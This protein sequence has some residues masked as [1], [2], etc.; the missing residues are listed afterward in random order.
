MPD[1][2]SI[3]AFSYKT[4]IVDDL[5]N[6]H[7]E[8]VGV[9]SEDNNLFRATSVMLM[10]SSRAICHSIQTAFTRWSESLIHIIISWSTA[11]EIQ[12][13]P[14]VFHSYKSAFMKECV[15]GDIPYQIRNLLVLHNTRYM[16]YQ[17]LQLEKKNLLHYLHNRHL[18]ML[19]LRTTFFFR[20]LSV[21]L[22]T[23]EGATCWSANTVFPNGSE[24]LAPVIQGL[25]AIE[26]VLLH[27]CNIPTI[28]YLEA[29]KENIASI[30]ELVPCTNI[31]YL[32]Q[33]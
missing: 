4:R 5:H 24:S 22:M 15:I 6:R 18:L 32:I 26:D 23:S 31:W 14:C 2:S 3:N 16:I 11:K 28:D 25:T 13:K 27:D 17:C 12:W 10:D 29:V 33:A 7:L 1:I 8:Q 20:A 9:N 19:P 21:M 30:D